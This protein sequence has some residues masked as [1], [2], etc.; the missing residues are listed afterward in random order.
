M[1]WLIHMLSGLQG[2][3]ALFLGIIVGAMAAF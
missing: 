3:S 2:G 1:A